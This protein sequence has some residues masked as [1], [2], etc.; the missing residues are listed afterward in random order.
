MTDSLLYLQHSPDFLP[1]ASF[2]IFPGSFPVGFADDVFQ[3]YLGELFN[4]FGLEVFE[5]ECQDLL[6]AELSV[7]DGRTERGVVGS[8]ILVLTFKSDSVCRQTTDFFFHLFLF[9]AKIYN[10]TV[11]SG[12]NFTI[13]V[14][15][16]LHLRLTI[17]QRLGKTSHFRGYTQSIRHSVENDLG[18]GFD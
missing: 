12:K 5:Y 11:F 2:V 16:I 4:E 15:L 14:G 18:C 6:K 9:A 13:G 10:H 8:E 3:A 7:A 1:L 17:L